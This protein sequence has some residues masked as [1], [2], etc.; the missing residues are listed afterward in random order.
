MTPQIKA[1]DDESWLRFNSA[2][3]SSL[4]GNDYMVVVVAKEFLDG[5]AWSADLWGV[6]VLQLQ[7]MQ[8]QIDHF[9]T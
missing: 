5:G 7:S 1:A 9:S 8:D 6:N 3:F 4:A 2:V